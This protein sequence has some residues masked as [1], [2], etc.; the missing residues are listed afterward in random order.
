MGPTRPAR[1]SAL[2]ALRHL[3]YGIPERTPDAFRHPFAKMRIGAVLKSAGG[4]VLEVVRR[5]GRG[6]TLRDADDKTAIEETELQRFLNGVDA[7]LFATMF[8]IGYDDLV[9]GG[10]EIIQGGGDLGRLIF[11]A[12]S[13]ASNL[14]ALLGELQSDADTLFRPTGQKQKINDAVGRLK[15]H[16]SVLK[17]SQLPGQEWARHDRALK[18]AQAQKMGQR[19]NLATLNA[20]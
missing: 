2:R 17:E 16:R 6:G 18:T 9:A 8:G 4:D 7:D 5:K 11:A 19:K 3:L 15:Q 13:G 10:R 12:G 1:A 14:G 20:G